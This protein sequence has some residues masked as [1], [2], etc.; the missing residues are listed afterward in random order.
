MSWEEKRKLAIKMYEKHGNNATHA[1][2]AL[3][4]ALIETYTDRHRKF[5]RRAVVR[6]KRYGKAGP[7]R[8]VRKRKISDADAERCAK[9]VAR[10]LRV[11][12]QY[13]PFTSMNDA[14]RESAEIRDVM[15]K[16]GCCQA[17]LVRSLRRAN[18]Q[19]KYRSF[20]PKKVIKPHQKKR[21]RDIVDI[22]IE[23]TGKDENLHDRTIWMDAASLKCVCHEQKGWIDTSGPQRTVTDSGISAAKN[24]RK[25]LNYYAAVNP[26]AGVVGLIFTT[27]TTGGAELG[28]FKNVR[29]RN[30]GPWADPQK[31]R[32][33]S[34]IIYTCRSLQ[35]HVMGVPKLCDHHTKLRPCHWLQQTFTRQSRLA[36]APKSG[37][38]SWWILSTRNPCSNAMQ[39][40]L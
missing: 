25:Q 37:A 29:F 6:R 19:L 15:V 22:L 26:L 27:G 5:V 36:T 13:R 12:R 2:Q 33:V 1:G 34:D 18:P 23:Q 30:P 32:V 20:V 24:E 7:P 35:P 31:P 9:I 21:R 16:A 40:N 8:G 10:G 3:A 14:I 17:T 38:S 4:S 28:N 11:G 39:F